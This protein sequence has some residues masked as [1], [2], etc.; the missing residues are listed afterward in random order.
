ML[1]G[2]ASRPLYFHDGSAA[3]RG[4]VIDTYETRF[5]IGFTEQKKT[6]LIAFLN[7]L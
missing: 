2:L 6:D 1:R 7:A 4:E 3:D 5:S